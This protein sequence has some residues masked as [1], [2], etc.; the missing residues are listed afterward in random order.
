MPSEVTAVNFF[1]DTA[2]LTL[3]RTTPEYAATSKQMAPASMKG[4]E[5]SEGIESSMLP[6]TPYIRKL[7]KAAKATSAT[8]ASSARLRIEQTS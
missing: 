2:P 4:D 8:A 6:A 7:P 3:S 5:T 1:R